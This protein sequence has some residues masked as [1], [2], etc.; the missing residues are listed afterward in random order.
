MPLTLP[1]HA[2]ISRQYESKPLNDFAAWICIDDI[3]SSFQFVN[4]SSK[5]RNSQASL[6]YQQYDGVSAGYSGDNKATSD[7]LDSEGWLKTGDLCYFDSNGY[8]FI[9][10]RLKELIKYKAYQVILFL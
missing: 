1:F 10:D 4:Q 2:F 6:F 9:V 7:T 5:P 3:I 8:L